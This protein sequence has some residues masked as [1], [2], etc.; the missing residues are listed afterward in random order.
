MIDHIR[1]YATSVIAEFITDK[2][3]VVGQLT[4]FAIRD[5]RDGNVYK[6][7]RE[8]QN[9]NFI[10]F[11]N[12]DNRFEIS[13]SLQK[14]ATENNY[15]PSKLTDLMSVLNSISELT[16]IGMDKFKITRMEVGFAF[17]VPFNVMKFLNNF[18]YYST[19]L[20]TPM[21]KGSRDY[22]LKYFLSE[23]SIKLYDKSWH[24]KQSGENIR[25]PSN[26]IRVEITLKKDKLHKIIDSASM[27]ASENTLVSLYTTLRGM[28]NKI[29]ILDDVD[30]SHLNKEDLMLYFAGENIDYWNKM[31][32]LNNDAQK[33]LRKKYREVVSSCIRN[34]FKQTLIKCLDE[35]FEYFMNN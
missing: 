4:L 31:K 14:S 10:F 15:M 26:I 5:S 6:Y 16:E 12:S 8:F 11:P 17:Q 20:P 32:S 21:K 7:E 30:T 19:I 24:V 29:T 22:G 35:A 18:S 13:N 25:I 23:Y 9:L 27:L 33:Y 2:S 34:D 28:I 3:V 1:M